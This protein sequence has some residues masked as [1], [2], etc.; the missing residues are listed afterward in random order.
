MIVEYEKGRRWKKIVEYEE[1]KRGEGRRW[2]KSVEERGER[3]AVQDQAARL[4]GYMAGDLV[5][6]RDS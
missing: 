1:E 4:I 6:G 3:S 5:R 2:E